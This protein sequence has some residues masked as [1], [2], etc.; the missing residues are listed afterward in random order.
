MGGSSKKIFGSIP[1]I[2]DVV[3]GLESE[4]AGKEAAKQREAE[5]EESR[6][7]LRRQQEQNLGEARARAGASGI[8]TTG[9]TAAFIEDLAANYRAELNWLEKSGAAAAEAERRRGEIAGMQSY[10]RAFTNALSLA[11][12]GRQMGWWGGGSGAA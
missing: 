10:N 8:K 5:A 9:S 2:G 11:T 1:V 4:K 6:R 3:Q 12:T 7:R